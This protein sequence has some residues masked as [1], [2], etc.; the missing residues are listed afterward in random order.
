MNVDI[1]IPYNYEPYKWEIEIIQAF[2]NG[3][4]IWMNNHRR[5]GKDLLCFC[6]FLLPQA[7][8]I[9]GTYQYIWPTLKEGRDGFWE[10]KDEDGRDILDY[11]IPKEMIIKPDNQDMRL[12][13]RTVGGG[14]SL[15]QVFGTNGGQYNS[16]RGKPS[17][18]ALFSEYAYQDPRGLEVLSPMI[19]K[20]KG[21]RA[22]N[23]T[24]NGQNFFQ[25]G[26]DLA[27]I[28]PRCFAKTFT[29]KD[30]YDHNGNPLITE[31]QIEEERKAGRSE[32][33]IMQDYYCSFNQGIEGTYIGRQLQQVRNDGRITKV[34][35]EPS[36]LV[37]TYWDLGVG[38]LMSIWFVQQLAKEIRIIDYREGTGTTFAY[39]KR[40]FNETGY[41]FGRHFAPFDLWV[42]EMVGKE[43]V[44]RTRFDWAE[45]VGIHFDKVPDASFEN[46]VDA[47]RGIL[48]LCWFDEEK[49]RV[50]R[51]HLEQ[52]GRV[53]NNIEQRYTDYE[54]RD[55]HTH[56]GAAARYMAIAIRQAQ[57]YDVGKSRE[58][59]SFKKIYRR[60]SDGSAMSV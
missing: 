60:D 46:G 54:K 20:T 47:I 7:F 45:K 34:P 15:I 39:W 2:E 49:T 29:V 26:Y 16:L 40:I 13:V 3:K 59:T 56:A 5:S 6:E 48:N 57:G 10:G 44:A 33:Y 30:T 35:Y 53:W 23:S 52:W 18:G 22:F 1:K 8:E 27:K 51:N 14:T 55:L 37:D 11:Y 31:A 24:P 17:N 43:E 50:G 9:P 41:L 12:T 38:E 58:E 42:R 21:W 28:N 36:L 25:K 32:D 4:E 19:V